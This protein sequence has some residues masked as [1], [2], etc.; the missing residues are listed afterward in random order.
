MLLKRHL[1]KDA[2]ARRAQTAHERAQ[3]VEEAE[4]AGELRLV[5][6]AARRVRVDLARPT[7]RHEAVSRGVRLAGASSLADVR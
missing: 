2:L 3:G 4:L 7:R 1:W 6:V 5:V